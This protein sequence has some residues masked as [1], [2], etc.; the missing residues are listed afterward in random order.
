[1]DH[2]YIEMCK[3]SE[4]I[5]SYC[6]FND[7]D[8]LAD[9]NGIVYLKVSKDEDYCILKKRTLTGSCCSLSA[10]ITGSDEYRIEK[11]K[12]FWVPRQDDVQALISIPASRLLDK[13]IEYYSSL[14][15]KPDLPEKA[16]IMFYMDFYENSF[17]NGESWV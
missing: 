17:W 15:S 11:S 6:M 13:F 5:Q 16:W 14:K 3:R 1:M 12:L 7:G 10:P 8:L 9:E 2:E 4:N